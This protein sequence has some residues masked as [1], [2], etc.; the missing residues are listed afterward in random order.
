ML[1]PRR[2]IPDDEQE[3]DARESRDKTRTEI[4]KKQTVNLIKER[5]Q[6]NKKD[7]SGNK[8]TSKFLDE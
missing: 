7:T 4:Y 3:D 1:D 6:E 8:N 2:Q 5:K